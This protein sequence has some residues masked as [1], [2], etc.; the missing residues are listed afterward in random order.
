MKENKLSVIIALGKS[1]MWLWPFISEIF[2][3]GKAFKQIV[4]ENKVVS[5]LTV[6]LAASVFFHYLSMTAIHKMINK[7]QAQVVP[8]RRPSSEK[9]NTELDDDK[10][11]VNDQL[12]DIFN[13]D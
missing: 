9:K 11:F 3:Q 5:I 6:L 1:L 2:F 12:K 7:E 4:K 13:S 10:K 8:P